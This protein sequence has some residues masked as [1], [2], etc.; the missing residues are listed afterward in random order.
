MGSED[1]EYRKQSKYF[2][3]FIGTFCLVLTVGCNVLSG[4][5]IWGGVSIACVLM[6]SIYALGNVSGAHF[7]PAVSFALWLNGSLGSFDLVMYICV[8]FSGGLFAALLY[9]ALF[10]KAF[11][12]QPAAYAN[13]V[14]VGFGE[15]IYTWML[16]FVVLNV[17]AAENLQGNSFYGL[18]I[19]FVI[20]AGAYAAGPICGGCFNPAVAF[21]IDTASAH[22]GWGWCISYMI[23][24]L[25]AAAFAVV[26]FRVVR[27]EQFGK[28]KGSLTYM[29]SEFFGTFMLVVTVG[30]NILAASPSG[31]F[32]IA[33]ALMCM[34]YA[35][36]DVSGAHFNPAVTLTVFAARVDPELTLGKC[37]KYLV[38]QWLGGMVG[39]WAFMFLALRQFDKTGANKG[40]FPPLSP[41]KD[42][43]QRIFFAETMFTFLLCFVVLCTAC[44][45][46]KSTLMFG[47][48]IGSCVTVGGNA[49]GSISGGSLNPAVTMALHFA[50][51]M[52]GNQC[53]F[54]GMIFYI[55][56]EFVG[57][58]L[59][60]VFFRAT[61]GQELEVED[62]MEIAK[63]A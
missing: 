18:A 3:E 38:A 30:L 33:A 58:A 59:G 54:L 29:I 12:L 62:T 60:A 35:L 23:Y 19:G 52:A 48:A 22:M 34:I 50:C 15:V 21:A 47:L 53:S 57:S 1:C 36:G 6:V 17:A 51:E 61:H 55:L 63:E 39:G 13:Y 42:S 2:A 27:P 4:N 46:R 25:V 31:A 20:V 26:C 44:S 28:E 56:F 24:E 7:N 49:I 43:W 9:E 40:M 14:D 41:D 37:M 45:K 11:N 8:Q 16:V 10:W 32:S 5:A